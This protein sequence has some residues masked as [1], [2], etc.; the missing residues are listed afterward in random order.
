M[1]KTN[2]RRRCG[3]EENHVASIWQLYCL[4]LRRRRKKTDDARA[5]AKSGHCPFN[6]TRDTITPLT[7]WI[8]TFCFYLMNKKRRNFTK[9]RSCTIFKNTY[10]CERF[11][12]RSHSIS[13]FSMIVR[14]NVVLNGIAV[15]VSD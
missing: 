13:R 7:S 2:L 11:E 9:L 14:V 10:F 12:R 4:F 15:V 5:C 1:S 6:L 8:I 3:P